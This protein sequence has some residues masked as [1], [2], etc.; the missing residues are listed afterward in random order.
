MGGK[1][2]LR[3]SLDGDLA[4]ETFDAGVV[5]VVAVDAGVAVAVDAWVVVVVVAV[6]AGIVAADVVIEMQ[7][8]I[9]L[10]NWTQQSWSLVEFG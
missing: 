10:L 1:E 7:G 9:D 6:D 8:A 4:F 3:E 5:V 2:G